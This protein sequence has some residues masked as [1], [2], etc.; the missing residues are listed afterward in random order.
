MP[1]LSI[2]LLGVLW[3]QPTH[4][5][6][7]VLPFL[8]NEDK[9]KLVLLN[10]TI[11]SYKYKSYHTNIQLSSAL[12]LSPWKST[13]K[14]SLSYRHIFGTFTI[15]IFFCLVLQYGC[16]H[17]RSQ[18]AE[19]ACV[20]VVHFGVPSRV[21]VIPGFLSQIGLGA[22]GFADSSGDFWVKA[23]VKEVR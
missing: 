17:A 2:R 3:L 11:V 9:Q 13:S 8:N 22:S 23:Q 12:P 16:H 18:T 21:F 7:I 20:V 10:K 15:K 1:W 6:N 19:N 14:S 5:L 4:D